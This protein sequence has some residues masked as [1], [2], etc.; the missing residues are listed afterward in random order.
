MGNGR[1]FY[2]RIFLEELYKPVSRGNN[3]IR[4]SFG[5]EAMYHGKE[6]HLQ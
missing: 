1:F 6:I 2:L 3:R 5:K 4:N